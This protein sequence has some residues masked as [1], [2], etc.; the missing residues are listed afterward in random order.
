MAGANKKLKIGD[1]VV[2]INITKEDRDVISKDGKG[3]IITGFIYGFTEDYEEFGARVLVQNVYDGHSGGFNPTLYDDK[4][5]EIE[6][7]L[8]GR[9][10]YYWV[11]EKDLQPFSHY[12][13]TSYQIQHILKTCQ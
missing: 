2:H 13:I 8:S 3:L 11:W 4:R 5:K 10:E 1:A 7:S 6:Y 12:K 9:R